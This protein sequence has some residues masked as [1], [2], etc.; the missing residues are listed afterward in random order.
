MPRPS[1]RRPCNHLHRTRCSE[2]ASRSFVRPPQL[3]ERCPGHPNRHCP[4][5]V[6][7]ACSPPPPCCREGEAP[8]VLLGWPGSL[9]EGSS[10]STASS[11]TAQRVCRQATPGNEGEYREAAEQMVVLQLFTA[12]ILLDWF[13]A[14]RRMWKAS[15]VEKSHGTQ[16]EVQPA[17][18]QREYS[19]WDC[20]QQTSWETQKRQHKCSLAEQFLSPKAESFCQG[21]NHLQ[22]CSSSNCSV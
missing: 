11:R 20:R 8:A 17:A 16:R 18:V 22:P 5:A 9:S 3:P 13:M 1:S 19:Y 15:S 21:T 4:A 12:P 14:K 10:G 2:A 6:R 7:A